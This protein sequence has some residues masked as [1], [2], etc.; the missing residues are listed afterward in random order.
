MAL[1]EV[2]PECTRSLYCE[3]GM[4]LHILTGEE[5]LKQGQGGSDSQEA[6]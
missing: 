6:Y 2:N 4:L 3:G 5:I 1:S